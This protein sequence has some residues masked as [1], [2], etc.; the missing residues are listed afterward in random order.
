MSERKPDV[1]AP[2]SAHEAEEQQKDFDYIESLWDESEIAFEMLDKDKDNV[3]YLSDARYWLRCLGWCES[4]KDLDVI[5]L[6]GEDFVIN[7]DDSEE[8]KEEKQKR[9]K[10]KKFTL[11][12]LQ[13]LAEAHHDS[14]SMLRK[15]GTDNHVPP[16]SC[17]TPTVTDESDRTKVNIDRSKAREKRLCSLLSFIS[18]GKRNMSRQ[19][20]KEMLTTSYGEPICGDDFEELLDI[21]GFGAN[22]C[23]GDMIDV[24][25][26]AENLSAKIE[27]PPCVPTQ[28]SMFI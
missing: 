10:Q 26:L 8:I 15:C 17:K 13:A 24:T 9:R 3:L 21:I 22:L 14:F 1:I 28:R 23:G 18:E 11:S 20:L 2:R 16:G 25:K 6:Q 5:L 4:D 7:E 19:V 12:E 27:S